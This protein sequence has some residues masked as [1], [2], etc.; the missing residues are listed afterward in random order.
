MSISQHTV[1]TGIPQLSTPTELQH[2]STSLAPT[3]VD[4]F[5][6]GPYDR[7]SCI[8]IS[9]LFSLGTILAFTTDNLATASTNNRSDRFL[10]AFT[11]VFEST[12]A[13]PFPH[14]TTLSSP[15]T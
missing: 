5:A 12:Q 10:N 15:P 13:Q 14:A 3:A 7:A 1:A 4:Q 6:A 11:T 8:F 9:A 2:T